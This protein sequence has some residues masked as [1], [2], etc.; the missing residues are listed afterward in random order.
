MLYD[1]AITIISMSQNSQLCYE[2]VPNKTSTFY[3][4]CFS[5]FWRTPVFPDFR[6]SFFANF[7]T[8]EPEG[9]ETWN[10]DQQFLLF[11]E[12]R[13]IKWQC[14]FKAETFQRFKFFS[15]DCVCCKNGST[16][17][18]GTQVWYS[19]HQFWTKSTVRKLCWSKLTD[20]G[21]YVSTFLKYAYLTYRTKKSILVVS[22][23]QTQWRIY[24]AA[25]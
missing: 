18:Y 2:Q 11:C 3:W 8:F 10:Q 15:K 16:L 17:R 12:T 1:A 5:K 9:L 7:T 25:L 4:R 14:P 19:T 20:A 21:S 6:R 22:K 13:T 24:A 23:R